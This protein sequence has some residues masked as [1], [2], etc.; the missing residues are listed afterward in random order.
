MFTIINQLH[1]TIHQDIHLEMLE[2]KKTYNSY[3]HLS[4]NM[5]DNKIYYKI[6]EMIHTDIF[7]S[8]EL[9]TLRQFGIG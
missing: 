7:S 5:I 4:H 9:S 8:L 2:N 3:W 6:C 1:Y